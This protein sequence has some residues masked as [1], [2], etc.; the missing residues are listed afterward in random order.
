MHSLYALRKA[1]RQADRDKLV[2][3]HQ[4][5]TKVGTW[6]RASGK[7]TPQDI[8]EYRMSLK[9]R[10]SELNKRGPVEDSNLEARQA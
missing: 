2:I 5:T 4:K 8:F 7:A 10:I 1:A 9:K 6:E 3:E